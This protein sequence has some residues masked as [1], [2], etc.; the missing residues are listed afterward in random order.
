[1]TTLVA[2][3]PGFDGTFTALTIPRSNPTNLLFRNKSGHPARF[4]LDAFPDPDSLNPGPVRYCTA[5]VEDGGAQALTLRLGQSTRQIV[6][7]GNP[8]YEFV[9][10]GSDVSLEVIV[11]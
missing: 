5:L 10:A 4:V 2:D 6:A 7:A 8:G 11:P 1:G 3:V 9:V